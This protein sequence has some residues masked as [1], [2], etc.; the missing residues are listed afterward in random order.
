MVSITTGN[1]AKIPIP[2]NVI[3]YIFVDPPFGANLMYSELNFLAESWLRVLTNNSAEVIES[4]V[5]GKSLLD[6]QRLMEKCFV[7]YFR[8]LKPGR[9]MTVEFSNTKASVWNAIQTALQQAGFVV[10]NVATLDKQQ[11]SFKAVTTPTA[12]KQDLV[13]SCYKPSHNLEMR[14]AHTDG[15][16][17]IWEFVSTHLAYLPVFIGTDFEV[18]EI[19]E[20]TH[21][22]LYDRIVAY[23]VQHDRPVPMSSQEFQAGLTER[24]PERDGMYFLPEQVAEHERRRMNVQQIQQLQVF[25]SD[26]SSAIQWIRRQL[27]NKPQTTGELTP[28][29]LQ[30]LSGW[31][32][33]E[34]QLE[35]I[36]LLQENF[37]RYEA[38]GPIPSQIVS[39]L[40]KSSD[41]RD[42][43]AREGHELENG[44][45]ETDN[46]QLH[47]RARDRWYIP[48]PNRAIDLEKLRLK[49]LLK[50]F[51]AYQ[52]G[53]GKLKQF[54][55]EAVRAGF[56]QAWRDKDY[57][58]I[59]RMAERLP[60]SVLQEDPDLLMYYDNASLRVD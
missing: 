51:A 1:A 40:K 12:V 42:L 23:F 10:A 19:A 30:E 41:L 44:D 37:L 3:D 45:L 25:V 54:R 28:Q 60:E 43:I 2:S 58:T 32:K 55:T 8:V 34:I 13:I 33:H 21:R 22:I 57:A 36:E 56:A 59:V 6:Y 24:F 16:A 47:G 52:S 9:W 7:E 50:E 5:H 26:E 48:D 14:F 18:A 15:E 4:K 38:T 46:L 20:R 11:G 17:G 49:G 39:W 27:T 31:Q 53:R 29:F 35:L